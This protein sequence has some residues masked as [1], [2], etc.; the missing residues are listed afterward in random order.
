[1]VTIIFEAHATSLDNEAKRAS[2]WNEVKLSELGENQAKELGERY[3]NNQPDAIFCSD[4]ERAYQTAT[5]AFGFEPKLIFIDWRLRECNYG[6]MTLGS[7]KQVES[8]KGNRIEQSF[9]NGE[10]YNDCGERIKSFL[11]DLKA[12][13]DGQT[14]MIIGHRATQYGLEHWLNNKPLKQAVTEPWTWQ[15]GWRYELE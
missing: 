11:D 6:D 12:K 1:M 4:L 2:G 14:V 15:P 10:S 8:E 13:F 7:S 9:P 3:E 5:I